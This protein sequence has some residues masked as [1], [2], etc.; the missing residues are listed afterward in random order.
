MPARAARRAIAFHA[1]QL[2]HYGMAI[3]W[4]GRIICEYKNGHKKVLETN[5]RLTPGEPVV[6]FL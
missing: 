5:Q 4:L 3:I 6:N 1:D 2:L